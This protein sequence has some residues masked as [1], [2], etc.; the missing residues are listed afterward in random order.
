MTTIPL[1]SRPPRTPGSTGQ[2]A[3]RA[4]RISARV[5][6]GALLTLYGVISIYPFL[7]MVSAAFKDQAEVVRRF[8]F[9]L[10]VERIR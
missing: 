3:A 7:W 5:L 1:P 4:R 8:P 10:S 2:G 6:V 9:R